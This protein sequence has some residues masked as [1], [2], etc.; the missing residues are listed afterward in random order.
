MARRC[1]LLA[2]CRDYRSTIGRWLK[3]HRLRAKPH[4]FIAFRKSSLVV[5]RK[6]DDT[7]Q[8][9][10]KIRPR[11]GVKVGHLWRAH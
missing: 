3:R 11:G 9:R 8:R 2:D 5:P 7:C 1:G 4:E 6:R 10:S